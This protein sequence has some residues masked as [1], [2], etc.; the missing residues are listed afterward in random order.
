MSEIADRQLDRWPL[1]QP[2]PL[3]PHMQAITLEVILRVVFGVEEPGRLAELRTLLTR[4]MVAT[5]RPI[6]MAPWLRR[7]LGPRSPWA[8]FKRL[9]AEVDSTLYE[10]IGRRRAA[11]DLAERDDICRCWSRHATRTAGG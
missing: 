2:F 11:P 8:R 1:R 7:D 3:Q 9:L 5:A 6:A 10:E 4:L